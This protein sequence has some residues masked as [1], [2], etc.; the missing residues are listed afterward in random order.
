MNLGFELTTTAADFDPSKTWCSGTGRYPLEQGG[1]NVAGGC[2]D[3]Y[4][5]HPKLSDSGTIQAHNPVYDRE[6]SK[7]AA[8]SQK[9][10]TVMEMDSRQGTVPMRPR[11]GEV[12]RPSTDQRKVRRQLARTADIHDDL[13]NWPGEDEYYEHDRKKKDDDDETKEAS[14]HLAEVDDFTRRHL[15]AFIIHDR[16]WDD[17]ADGFREYA[18]KA[19]SEDPDLLD[20]G[21]PSIL[22]AYQDTLQRD[23]NYYFSRKTARHD[24]IGYTYDADV[25]CPGCAIARFGKEDGRPWVRG[26]AVDHEGNPIGVIAPW[27]ETA[28]EGEYCGTCG[29]Q[30]A[31]PHDD[32]LNDLHEDAAV[33]NHTRHHP[34]QGHMFGSRMAVLVEHDADNLLTFTAL[35]HLT[36]TGPSAGQPICGAPRSSG[37]DNVHAAYAPDWML[38]SPDT[39]AK[40]RAVWATGDPD[41]NPQTAPDERQEM[42]FAAARKTAGDYDEH[43]SYDLDNLSDLDLGYNRGYEVGSAG[44]SPVE[45]MDLG[46]FGVGY[47]KG[48]HDG[49]QEYWGRNTASK[50]ACHIVERDGK[51]DVVAGGKVRGSH[52]SRADAE[53]Q[54]EAIEAS[55]S[56]KTIGGR[57]SDEIYYLAEAAGITPEEAARWYNDADSGH[58]GA[59]EAIADALSPGWRAAK[60]NASNQ[61]GGSRVAS[62]IDTIN[63]VLEHGIYGDDGKTVKLDGAILDHTSAQLLKTIYDALS[64][65]E[66]RAKFERLPLQTLMDFAWKQVKK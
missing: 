48:F 43:H 10:Q 57:S 41:A 17:E 50:Q 56:L 19:V 36:L 59:R 51:Y 33:E 29:G 63:Q 62:R 31:P 22:H 26:D 7:T 28:P 20:V 61:S 4:E 1:W 53:D 8:N 6:A 45:V 18:L 54:R 16:V 3:C 34:G 24:P 5:K 12:R 9:N 15:D 49:R 60:K 58:E 14:R 64:T 32:Y 27:D 13:N 35:R 30:I 66:A 25:H 23:P 52:D 2:P 11:S 47:Q 42:L 37:D 38:S 39:C 44:G 40:C 46:D 65:D 55:A 21:W